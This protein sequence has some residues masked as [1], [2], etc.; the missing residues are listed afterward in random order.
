MNLAI[1]VSTHDH[2]LGPSN[3]AV[4]LVEYGDFQCPYCGA[5]YGELKQVRSSL[6]DALRFVFRHMPLTAIHPMAELAAEA[7]EA[8]GVQGQFWPMH[9]ALYENQRQLS[10]S[11][12]SALATRLGLDMARFT[13][14]LRSRR[15]AEKVRQDSAG[16][17][18]SGVQGTPSFFIDGRPYSGP[19]DA[20]TL[21]DAL[22]AIATARAA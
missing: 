14:D 2:A 10:P 1:A 17:E 6:G 11:L 3:A 18:R 13:A 22:R 15:Y 12:V 5:A 19:Y 21:T 9:D 8:A 20:E 7:A 16:A 4:T